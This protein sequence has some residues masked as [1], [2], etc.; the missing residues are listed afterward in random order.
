MTKK[1]G[2]PIGYV[3]LK[4]KHNQWKAELD[5]LYRDDELMVLK[6]WPNTKFPKY[7]LVAKDLSEKTWKKAHNFMGTLNTGGIQISLL[8][9][10]IESDFEK[11]N[12]TFMT[13]EQRREWFAN[14]LKLHK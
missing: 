11:V 3:L 6:D 10:E 2:N 13:P 8:N 5:V 4:S 14:L 7:F 9:E 1:F 12:S